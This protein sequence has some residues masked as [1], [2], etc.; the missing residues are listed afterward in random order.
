MSGEEA[1]EAGE[2]LRFVSELASLV[3]RLLG[4]DA[5]AGRLRA[6]LE[7]AKP[8]LWCAPLCDGLRPLMLAC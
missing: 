7:A 1:A 4:S 8:G 2:A 5:A 6:V 3:G